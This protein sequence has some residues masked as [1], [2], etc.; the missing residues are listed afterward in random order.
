MNNTLCESTLFESTCSGSTA[1]R[2]RSIRTAWRS[3]ACNP[4]ESRSGRSERSGA[5]R[6]ATVVPESLIRD[7][8]R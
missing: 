1:P 6:Y 8:R 3:V 4:A 7:E 5:A 2:S